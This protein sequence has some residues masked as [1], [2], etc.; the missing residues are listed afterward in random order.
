MWIEQVV[1]GLDL[2]LTKML[3]EETAEVTI[4][5][6]HAFGEAGAQK[7]LASV[8]S[9][10]T[11]VYTVELVSVDNPKSTW[12][13]SNEEKVAD[14]QVK[15]EKGNQA[16]KE[17]KLARAIK[18]YDAAV[19]AIENDKDFGSVKS[20]A[21]ELKK[22]IWLNLAAAHLKSGDHLKVIENCGKV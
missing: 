12:D 13:M 3:K 7:E 4:Q 16:Y 10:A 20:T 11:V 18:R 21:K 15:K 14:A 1:D 8:P 2:A 6:S 22:A 9:N 19:K 17:G 5:P